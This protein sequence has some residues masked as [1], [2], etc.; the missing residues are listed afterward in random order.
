MNTSQNPPGISCLVHSG[1]VA[2]QHE[3]SFLYDIRWILI[4]ITRLRVRLVSSQP[5]VQ[6]SP[7]RPVVCLHTPLFVL[8]C[9]SMYMFL[10]IIIIHQQLFLIISHLNI[11]CILVMCYHDLLTWSKRLIHHFILFIDVCL[12]CV[13]QFYVHP[14][15]CLSFLNR[16][17]TIPRKPPNT[18][19]PI[20]LATA[21]TNTQYQY[22]YQCVA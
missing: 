13:C 14:V 11:L 10:H 16:V 2:K 22:W 3:S 12:K 5:V 17:R 4:I 18:Q 7:V 19:Y 15:L 21:D 8:V 1:H 9:L 20:V 6:M